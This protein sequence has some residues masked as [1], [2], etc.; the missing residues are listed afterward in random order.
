MLAVTCDEAPGQ[1]GEDR[2]L[3]L[4]LEPIVNNSD[5]PDLAVGLYEPRISGY[6]FKNFLLV[7]FHHCLQFPGK[8]IV[9]PLQNSGNQLFS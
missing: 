4:S 3:E 8:L 9:S 2:V 7:S 1:L 6:R 5:N